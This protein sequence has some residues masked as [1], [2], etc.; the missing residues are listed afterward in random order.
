M[1]ERF[2]AANAKVQI[3]AGNGYGPGGAG[4]MRMNLRLPEKLSIAPTPA[5]AL[6]NV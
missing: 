4:H 6:K 3:N 2:F 5:R 1:V